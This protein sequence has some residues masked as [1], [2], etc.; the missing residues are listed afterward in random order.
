MA[1][2]TKLNTARESKTHTKRLGLS[3]TKSCFFAILLL[4]IECFGERQQTAATYYTEKQE[5]GNCGVEWDAKFG[6]KNK[7]LRCSAVT[8]PISKISS[9]LSIG[10]RT[11]CT[12][13]SNIDTTEYFEVVDISAGSNISLDNLTTDSNLAKIILNNSDFVAKFKPTS[14][15]LSLIDYMASIPEVRNF[16]YGTF[17]IV[18]KAESHL[19]IDFF[20]TGDWESRGQRL[21]FQ[22]P[23]PDSL[24]TNK[25]RADLVTFGNFNSF[26]EAPRWYK[27]KNISK[28]ADY[29]FKYTNK[30]GIS[31]E[32]IAQ[33]N[34]AGF[35]LEQANRAPE[36]I[37]VLEKVIGFDP[38]RTPA[39][40]NLADAYSKTGDKEKAKANYQKYVEL[41]EKSG[42]GAKVPA[43]VRA[44]LKP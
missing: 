19:L 22:I 33:F 42:K 43:R 10:Y 1:Q 31:I 16:D 25:Y 35:F 2:T 13:G 40:L 37:S 14:R 11:I 8:Y 15:P 29:A 6:C 23:I 18:S 39:Y 27:A 41:M 24:L 44:Y 38:T 30:S 36:A 4:C 5:S 12:D 9:A 21:K 32:N 26:L 20:I 34:D 7:K 28:S 17:S 3:S